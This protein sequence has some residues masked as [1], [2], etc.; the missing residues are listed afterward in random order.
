M[1]KFMIRQLVGCLLFLAGI[2]WMPYA[3]N[4]RLADRWFTGDPVLQTKLANGIEAWMQDG[5]DRDDFTTGSKHFDGEWLYGTYVMAAMGFG[6]MALEQPE[7]REHFCALM[8]QA[9]DEVLSDRVRAF[10][11]ERWKSDPVESLDTDEGHAAYLGYLNLAMGFHRRLNPDSK[12]TELNDRISAALCRRIEASPTLLLESYPRET[13]PVDNCAVI[14]S[15]ALN[16]A[17]DLPQRW[18]DRCRRHFTDPRSGL[19]HQSINGWTGQLTDFPRGSGTTLGLYFLSF[20][21]M[22]LS[23][24]LF[25]AVKT[26]LTGNICGF[27]LVREYPR[28]IHGQNGDIDSGAVIFGYGLS[29]TGFALGGTRIHGDSNYFKHLYATANAAGA[30]LQTGKQFNFVTGASLGDAILFA[31]LTAQPGGIQP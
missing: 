15:V 20:M 18:A 6:Q 3:W 31:M 26:Q 25:N 12:F 5:L 29:P 28:Y 21:D 13:Y 8:E 11:S 7:H 16:G 2:A 1:R 22:D 30:P 10:D 27:G 9:I 24:E 4:A 19:L 14:A 23:S 17:G